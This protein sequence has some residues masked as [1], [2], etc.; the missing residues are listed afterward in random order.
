V[1]KEFPYEP[2]PKVVID[3]QSSAPST[4][5][6]GIPQGTV[7]GP[8]LFL[9]YIN[10]LPAAVK[11]TAR[12]FADD[13]LL[14]RKIK[15][16]EDRRI[17][18]Q[19]LDTLQKWEDQWLMRF[20]PEKCEVLQVTSRRTQ[21]ESK[22]TIHGQVLNN[23]NSA[24]YLGLNIHKT[25]SWDDHINKVTK[26]AHNTLSFLGRNISRCRTNISEAI[27]GICINSLEPS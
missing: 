15:S 19:D 1:D 8:L 20:N 13:C 11:S 3:G 25:L 23:V 10:D 7:L 27:P 24:K 16:E 5:T 21:Q 6:S 4:A 26:K 17:L 2:Y 18:Q 14:Y 12:L 9:L 22:Y